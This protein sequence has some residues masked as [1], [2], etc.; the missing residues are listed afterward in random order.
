MPIV[1]AIDGSPTAKRVLERAIGQA[2]TRGTDLHVLHVFQP[3]TTVYW[4]EGAY[5]MEDETFAEAE[6]KA[7]W[8]EATDIL[9]ESGVE[10]VRADLR[11]HPATEITRYADEVDADLV[12]VGTRGRGALTSLILGSTSRGVIHDAHRDVLVV[13]TPDED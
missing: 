1:A 12:V 8:G 2:K 3:L 7:V 9:D 4:V 5:V 6:R 10:W 13:Q 11:G